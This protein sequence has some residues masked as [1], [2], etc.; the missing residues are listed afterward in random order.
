MPSVFSVLFIAML[1]LAV[2]LQLYRQVKRNQDCISFLLSEYSK[3][4]AERSRRERE[5]CQQ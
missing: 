5:K 4:R 2:N 1:V 3:Q